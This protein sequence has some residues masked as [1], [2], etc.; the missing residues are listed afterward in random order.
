[1]RCH[2]WFLYLMLVALWAVSQIVRFHGTV[3][4]DHVFHGSLNALAFLFFI[5]VK[6]F[7]KKKVEEV[8]KMKETALDS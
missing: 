3:D 7:L 6:E 1:M 5:S 8:L 4:D 2:G